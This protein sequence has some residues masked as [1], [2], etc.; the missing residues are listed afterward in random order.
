MK[1][2]DA[3]RSSHE[4]GCRQFGRGCAIAAAGVRGDRPFHA[5]GCRRRDG[6]RDDGVGGIWIAD[7]N[8]PI[9]GNAYWM[10]IGSARAPTTL[11]YGDRAYPLSVE[12]PNLRVK[13]EVIE[14]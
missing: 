6:L 10:R 12:H 3:R 7:I 4:W 11:V 13:L 8:E 2:R 9:P 5:L 1:V 14:P